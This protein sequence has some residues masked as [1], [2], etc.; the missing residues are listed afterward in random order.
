MEL[1]AGDLGAAFQTISMVKAKNS[2]PA[3]QTLKLTLNDRMLRLYLTGDSV[4]VGHCRVKNPDGEKFRWYVDRKALETF[5]KGLAADDKVSFSVLQDQ[6]LMFKVGRRTLRVANSEAIKGYGFFPD[7]KEDEFTIGE[8]TATDLRLVT[9]Y[10]CEDPR[11]PNLNCIYFGDGVAL[12]TDKLN[13]AMVHI[14]DRIVGPYPTE[15]LKWLQYEGVKHFISDAGFRVK[16]AG[17]YVYQPHNREAQK[18][19]PM[20]KILNAFQGASKWEHNLTLPADRF[21]LALKSLRQY[22]TGEGE[23]SVRFRK[24]SGQSSGFLE[25]CR[26][27]VQAEEEVQVKKAADGDL[28]AEW[29]PASLLP[30]FE[31]AVYTEIPFV[32]VR[33][34]EGTSYYF[35]AGDRFHLLSPRF[36]GEREEKN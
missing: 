15:F 13:I 17:G 29:L 12:A 22:G 27:A 21:L 31:F 1:I 26:T 4:A 35:S 20:S 33:W 14:P 24:R 11:N 34:S 10:A 16:F 28:F 2:I 5:L 30:F 18:R 8:E 19:F 25:N 9:E 36:V 23:I 6:R 32:E 3:S 7:R